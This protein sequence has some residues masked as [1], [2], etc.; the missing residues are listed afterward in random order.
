ME[1]EMWK[2]RTRGSTEQSR[3]KKNENRKRESFGI[4]EIRKVWKEKGKGASWTGMEYNIKEEEF[5]WLEGCYVGTV[6]SVE[7]VRNLQ[8][9]FYMEGYFYCRVRAMGGKMVLLDCE[10]KEELKDLVEMAAEWLAQC[11]SE[12]NESW[13]WDTD[14]DSMEDGFRKVKEPA[15]EQ[16]LDVGEEDDEVAGVRAINENK[17][18]SQEEEV[19][20]DSLEKFQNSNTGAGRVGRLEETQGHGERL[21]PTVHRERANSAEIWE[22]EGRGKNRG[23]KRT[24]KMG[25][26]AKPASNSIFGNRAAGVSVGDTEIRNCNR[27]AERQRQEQQLADL[28]DFAKKLGVMAVD[29]QQ[30]VKRIEEMEKR[31]KEEK[32]SMMQLEEASTKKNIWLIDLPLVG[33][34]YTWYNSNGKYMSRIDR[35]LLIEEW[36]LKWGDM[37][38]WGLNRTVSDH[39]PI[40]LKNEK[41][42]WGPKP[43]KFFDAWLDQP[44]C[45]E[46]IR[47]VWKST[48]VRGWKGYKLKE[49]LKRTKKELKEWSR[50][51]ISEVDSKIM[52]VEKEIATINER[53]EICQLSTQDI[54]QRRNCFIELWKNL[55]IKESMWQQKSRKMWLKEGDANTKYFHRSVKGRWRRNEILCIRIN[56]VQ[57]IGVAEIKNEVAKYFEELFK[58]EKWERPKLDGIDFKRISEA[59]N[60]I[61]TAAFSEKEVKEAVWECE[62]SKSPGP[63]GFN[64]KFVKVMWEDIKSDVVEFVQEFHEQGKIAKGSNA[65]FIV[66]IPKEREEAAELQQKI[67]S[68]RIYKDIPDT[69]KWEHSKEGNYSTKSAY[70]LLTNELN[71]LDAAPIHKRVW[72]LI[73]PSKISAFNWQLLQDR[74][75]TKSNLQRKG[76]TTELD[77][78]TCALCEEEVED[79]NHLFLRCKVAKWLWKACGKWWGTS[80]NLGNY[81]WKTFEQFGAWAKEK[82]VKEGW[83]CIWNV[84]VW[85]IWL[86]RNQKIFRETD[87][88]KSKLLDHIQLK[89]FWWIKTRKSSCLFSLYDW[90]YNP[91]TCL[92]VNC[93]RK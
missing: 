61:L 40:L 88:N 74:I 57:H 93:G 26:K 68:M 28:W 62:S 36:I 82:R 31:D 85:T 29:E 92:K 9:K 35:F 84:V 45:K 6:H 50:N 91:M 24:A 73:I 18:Q 58:E 21:A 7:M 5:A 19:A 43:F 13:S 25:K 70:K 64:F 33:R 52:E 17:H 71:G 23:R 46:F 30:I 15:V 75:P 86:A 59:D 89:S 87:I 49:K 51:S 20:A 8:E 54:D 83:D 39:C 4:A 72:N 56:G 67:D 77:D 79:S 53:G 42:D 78:G 38:Q 81:C 34:R 12:E 3:R 47:E 16:N 37:K 44:G 41:M 1:L 11:G 76:I 27:L 32:A 60:D 80:V 2:E 22:K 48:I 10:E 65:S 63:D 66:L 69:W 90:L 55:K 14:M